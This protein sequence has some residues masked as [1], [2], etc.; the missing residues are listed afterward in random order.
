MSGVQFFDGLEFEDYF[1]LDNDVGHIV[2]DKLG[3]VIDLDLLFLFSL[4][5]GLY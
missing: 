3:V 4:E 2:A 1:S 5:V